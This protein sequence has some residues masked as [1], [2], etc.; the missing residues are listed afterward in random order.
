MI[1][2]RQ[3]IEYADYRE[4]E[5]SEALKNLESSVVAVA[6]KLTVAGSAGTLLAWA[7]SSNLGMWVGI[8]IGI[9]GLWLNYHYKR[10]NDRRNQDAHAAFMRRMQDPAAPPVLPVPVTDD[11]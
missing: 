3:L 6:N 4:E 8:A 11:A 5:M 1:P 9:G 2:V 7:T 10:K